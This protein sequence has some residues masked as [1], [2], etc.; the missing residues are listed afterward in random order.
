[1]SF[2]FGYAIEGGFAI[3]VKPGCA[4]RSTFC[5]KFVKFFS[6]L[7]MYSNNGS[8]W[9]RLCIGPVKV[10]KLHPL[11]PVAF[12]DFVPGQFFFHGRIVARVARN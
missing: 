9:P 8:V 1:M 4:R 3:D 7:R 2:S 10:N 11:V 5:G 12:F 6:R